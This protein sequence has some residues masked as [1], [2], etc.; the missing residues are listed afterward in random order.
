[1]TKLIL[2]ATVPL[3]VGPITFVVMQGLKG[4]SATVDALPPIA[5]RFAVAAI[6]VVLTV[7]SHLSG[8]EVAC[9]PNAAQDCLS[10]LDTDAVKG[11]VAAAI[12]Y[13]LHLA[14]QKRA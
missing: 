3:V 1:M 5:K 7:A 6:A 2:S 13:A 9:D 14:K 4:L 8:V 12:A 11:M 10:T